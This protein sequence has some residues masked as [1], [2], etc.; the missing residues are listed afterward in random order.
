VAFVLAIEPDTR[1][2]TLVRR[3]MRQEVRADLALVDSKDAAVAAIDQRMP[4]LILVTALMSPRDE[5]ELVRHLRARE[6]PPH[7]QTLTIPLLAPPVADESAPNAG[8]LTSLKRR[9]KKPPAPTGCDPIVFAREIIGYLE[10]AE[11]SRPQS[12]EPAD[13]GPVVQEE[14]HTAL[15][16]EPEVVGPE[17]FVEAASF[18][19]PEPLAPIL[20]SEPMAAT[21]DAAPVSVIV[22][23]D[24]PLAVTPVDAIV[25]EPLAEPLIATAPTQAAV[26]AETLASFEETEPVETILETEI[27]A[28]VADREPVEIVATAEPVEMVATTE[29]VEIV[30]AT[31][32][33]EI[34]AALEPIETVAETE[35]VEMVAAEPVAAAQESEPVVSVVE[36]AVEAAEIIEASEADATMVC[37]APEAV[38]LDGEVIEEVREPALEAT[39]VPEPAAEDVWPRVEVVEE[40]VVEVSPVALDVQGDDWLSK[41]LARLTED[42]HRAIDPPSLGF[43][44]LRRG[45]SVEATP[46]PRIALSPPP[47]A[48]PAEAAQTPEITRRPKSRKARGRQAPRVVSPRALPLSMWVR[49]N[50]AMVEGTAHPV[51]T[52]ALDALLRGLKLPQ[53]VAAVEYAR[54]CRIGRVRISRKKR[55]PR[56]KDKTAPV[57]VISARLLAKNRQEVRDVSGPEC[58]LTSDF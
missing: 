51:E 11:E 29:P 44:E 31:E 1:Q 22:E 8:L 4:D 17:S 19:E 35:P 41:A 15:T 55:G 6:A 28:H 54:G 27:V 21:V 13:T 2:A 38:V 23:P 43:S 58:F 18:V 32:A 20:E 52:H 12:P 3:L 5:A 26:E 50:P 49:A 16:V 39:T 57:I 14:P 45:K 24:E 9:R 36:E 53:E 25:E 37:E 7:L 10:R 42:L 48:S 33:V 47:P 56:Q 46:P 40:P 34:V 30:A